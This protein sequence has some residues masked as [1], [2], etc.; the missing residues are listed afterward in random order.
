M[1]AIARRAGV[2][3]NTIYRRWPNPG[4]VL[5]EAF[6]A[7][8]SEAIIT[9]RTASAFDDVVTL[10]QAAFRRL[11]RPEIGGVVRTLMAQSQFDEELRTNMRQKFIASRREAL[12]ELIE[13]GKQQGEFPLDLDV[14]LCLDLI[15]GAMWYRLLS[16]HSPLTAGFARQ[17][18]G[19]VLRASRTS[20]QHP[21]ENASRGLKG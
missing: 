12:A 3:K 14:E 19:H 8:T 10:L 18:A 5:L 15:Y 21:T 13:R 2:G 7:E 17:V 1:E 6:T 20:E 9:P 11:K 4:S 16:G